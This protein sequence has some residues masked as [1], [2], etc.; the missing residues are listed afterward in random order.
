MKLNISDPKSAK[1]YSVDA[2]EKTSL[3]LLGK[4]MKCLNF[5]I[6]ISIFSN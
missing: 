5:K 6:N 2:D 1:T 3:N 4:K